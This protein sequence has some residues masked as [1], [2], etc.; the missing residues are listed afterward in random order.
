[1]RKTFLILTISFLTWSLHAQV[2]KYSNEFLSIGISARAL[3]MANATAASVNDVTAGYW[4]PAGLT[5]I[6][7]DLQLGL[8]HAEYF[9]GIAK[10]DYAAV[11]MPLADKERMLG[12]SLIRFGV[13]DIPY[14]LFLI[15]PD[16]TINY[17]NITSFSVADYA[18]IVSYAQPIG[19]K[20]FRIGGNAKV[21]HRKAGS[22]ATAWGFG[23]D[24]GAQLTAGN[25][26][27][28]VMGRDI[29]TTFNAWSFN[30]T[31]EEEEKFAQTNNII[32]ENSYEITTPKII[33]ATAYHIEMGKKFGLLA[34][35][36]LDLTT[37]GKRNVVISAD[38]ISL[39]P[40]LGIEFNY[41]KF[42][43][44]R[45]GIG[46][47]QKAKSDLDGSDITTIQP[48]MGV[49]LKI[50]NIGIDYAYTDI[51][52]QSQVLYSHVF[53]LKIEINRKSK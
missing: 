29:T 44:L 46:N 41:D 49:G 28:G 9:A 50:K 45:G 34:E 30:F 17:D 39:D 35:L 13:D 3:G 14:T 11:A 10:Y 37:D 42:I 5:Y 2:R 36:N 18:F 8:M 16:G 48:N 27:F 22:F 40:H 20:N 7:N 47:I 24:L 15:E 21:I 4:N 1:M 6:E 38:P 32:P 51:G 43:F 33:L 12:F 31:E 23:I 52:N 26:L 53:S 19:Y 25:W